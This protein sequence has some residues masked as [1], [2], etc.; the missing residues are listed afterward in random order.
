MP[1]LSLP[2]PAPALH[3]AGS[4]AVEEA[5]P[6]DGSGFQFGWREHLINL[7]FWTLFGAV[8]A[9]IY[10]SNDFEPTGQ[11]NVL[12]ELISWLALAYMWAALTPVAF[13]AAWR[14]R[15]GTASRW[16]RL[17]LLIGAAL[18]VFLVASA[19]RA[20]AW[21]LAYGFPL[22]LGGGKGLE[23]LLF[24][25]GRPLS[26]PIMCGAIFLAGFVREHLLTLRA[27]QERGIRLE[28]HAAQVEAHAAQLQAQLARARLTMLRSQLNPHFLFNALNAVSALMEEDQ[29]RAQRMIARLSELLRFAL[30]D[31][32]EEEIPLREELRLAHHYLEILEIRFAGRLQTSVQADPAVK[33][34]L[35]PNLILQPLV[36][37]AMKHGVGRAGGRGRI[38]VFAHV[39]GETVVLSVRDTGGGAGASGGSEL[40]SRWSATGVG[41]TNTGARLRELYGEHQSLTLTPTPEGGMLAQVILPLRRAA[42]PVAV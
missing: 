34:V 42:E 7:G 6:R 9:T 30:E 11:R 39:A 17:P 5:P 40:G 38:E 12:P 33:D 28:A 35:V 32:E 3:R 36:E 31:R 1:S 16:L 18:G 10:L 21:H 13:W 41:L 14:Y 2:T 29:D 23:F 25:W 8:T 27:R 24:G 26:E 20:A 37:N 19:A 22:P 15:R 4:A